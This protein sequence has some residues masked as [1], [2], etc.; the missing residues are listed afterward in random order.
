MDL[1]ITPEPTEEERAA[2][3]KALEQEAAETRASAWAGHLLPPR[4][5]GKTVTETLARTFFGHVR[6]VH[7]LQ[8]GSRSR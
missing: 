5:E 1:E 7:P 6:R 8:R 2:I 3:A 4:N